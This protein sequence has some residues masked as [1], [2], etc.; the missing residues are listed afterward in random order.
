MNLPFN[1]F[2]HEPSS[3]G[4]RERP[5]D[6]NKLPPYISSLTYGIDLLKVLSGCRNPLGNFIHQSK[7][8]QMMKDSHCLSKDLWPCPIPDS[9]CWFEFRQAPVST[10]TRVVVRAHLR[11]FVASCNWLITGRPKKVTM[12]GLT[13]QPTIISSCQSRMLGSL[14]QSLR[15]W[16]RQGSGLGTD[17]QR[18]EQKFTSLH[19]AIEELGSTCKACKGLLASFDPYSRPRGQKDH[20]R[21]DRVVASEKPATRKCR[22][23]I[24]AVELNPDRRKFTSSPSF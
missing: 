2:P 5:M 9:T 11:V 8:L 18:S 20:P 3:D 13:R 24:T 23:D 15:I 12:E 14:E 22:S 6:S 21:D 7:V 16:Y 1:H 17:L 10:E 4:V 19:E